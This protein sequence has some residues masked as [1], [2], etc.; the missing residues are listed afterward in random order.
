MANLD[1]PFASLHY[2]AA[3]EVPLLWGRLKNG[4]RVEWQLEPRH[5]DPKAKLLDFVNAVA[6]GSERTPAQLRA[7][8]GLGEPTV[9]AAS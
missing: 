6:R 4:V 7:R 3:G 9:R 8:F 1:S 5:L 2:N